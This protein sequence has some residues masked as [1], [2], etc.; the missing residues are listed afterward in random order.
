MLGN[1]A[2][3][4]PFDAPALFSMPAAFIVAF[5]VSKLDSSAQAKAEIAAFDDQFVRAQTGLG[6]A[7]ASKH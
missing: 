1:P 6:A 5:I 3:I 7:A 2:G 4:F